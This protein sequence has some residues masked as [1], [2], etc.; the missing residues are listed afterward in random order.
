MDDGRVGRVSRVHHVRAAVVV[1]LL[2]VERADDVHVMHLLGHLGQ[3]LADLA[4]PGP[5]C[6]S[7]GTGRRS[8][9]SRASG[10]RCRGGSG[11]PTSRAR[12]SSGGPCGP[13][14]ALACSDEKNCIA[15]MP[16][17][18]GG[19]VAQEM[20]AARARGGIGADGRS[21]G[22]LLG[23]DRV[24]PAVGSSTG[25]RVADRPRALINGS[26]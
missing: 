3:V 18:G 4:R 10:P 5:R 26:G 17:R 19:Q 12:C 23:Q 13:A 1:A 8:S 6:R 15:G 11:R 2:R 9:R 16:R 20:A 24:R 7:A 21:R 14:A 25:M 22:R